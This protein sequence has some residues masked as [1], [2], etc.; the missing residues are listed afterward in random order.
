MA[1][2]LHDSQAAFTIM[3]SARQ[4]DPMLANTLAS[5]LSSMRIRTRPNNERAFE[6]WGYTRHLLCDVETKPDKTEEYTGAHVVPTLAMTA[7]RESALLKGV[8][9]HTTLVV[10]V[11]GGTG[12]PKRTPWPVAR[13]AAYLV[14]VSRSVSVLLVGGGGRQE[15]R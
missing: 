11:S 3:V 9:G 15:V 13:R 10:T 2:L 12:C 8:V 6:I 1:T 14:Y 4:A 5:L 7:Q